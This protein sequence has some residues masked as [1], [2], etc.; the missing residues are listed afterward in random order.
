MAPR[1]IASQIAAVQYD[2][3]GNYWLKK[4]TGDFEKTVFPYS[5]QHRNTKN[6]G[7][8]TFMLR[9]P[10]DLFA[11]L[12]KVMN[13]SDPRL[14]MIL[15]AGLVLLLNKYTGSRDIL[16]GTTIYRQETTEGEFINTLLPL[17]SQVDE[18]MMFKDLL[19]QVRQSM[20]EAVKNQNYPMETLIYQL[21]LSFSREEFPLFGT[22][23]LLDNIHDKRYI[24]H[25]YLDMLFLFRREEAYIEAQV[26]YNKHLYTKEAVERISAHFTR[27]L[28]K[29]ISDVQVQMSTVSPL[30]LQERKLLLEEFNGSEVP[31]PQDKTLH[32]LF[33]EQV[34]KSPLATAL[35]YTGVQTNGTTTEMHLT[36]GVLNQRSNRLARLLRDKGVDRNVIVT[37]LLDRSLEMVTAMLAVLKAGGAYLP[38]LPD[39]PMGRIKSIL[40]NSN[41]NLLLTDG[42]CPLEEVTVDIP[43]NVTILHLPAAY[44]DKD[45]VDSGP[46]NNAEPRDLVYVI[47]TSGSTGNP[48]GVMVEHRSAVNV[49][50]WFNR[51]YAVK[52]RTYVLQMSDFIFDASVNQIFGTLLHG[53]TLFLILKEYLTDIQWLRRHIDTR[54]INLINFV[55]LLLKELL[56]GKP[57]LTSLHTVIS[58]ADSL[59]EEMKNEIIGNGYTLY[60]HYG[61]TEATIDVLAAACPNKEVVLG[62]PIS[63]VRCYVLDKYDQLIPPGGIGELCAAGAGL[64]RG[65]LNDPQLT[66]DKF[67]LNPFEQAQLMYRTGDLV[68]WLPDGNVRFLGRI[69]Q[70]VKIRGFRIEL[71]EIESSLLTHPCVKEALVI[72]MED[73][74]GNKLLC[75]YF[76]ANDSPGEDT[77]PAAVELVKYLSDRLPLYMIPTYIIR[78]DAVPV[79]P[80]GKV[81]RKALPPP[82]LNSSMEYIPPRDQIEKKLQEIWSEV[83]AVANE[84]ISI[85]ADFFQLGGHSLKA[86]I[87]IARIHKELEVKLPL[88]EIFKTP[89]IRELAVYIKNQKKDKY[90]SIEPTEKRDYY[91]LSA[92]QKRLYILQQ[93]ESDNISYNIPHI[94]PLEEYIDRE[95]LENTFKKI[96]S[97]HESLRTS[98]EIVD[99]NPIQRIHQEADLSLE[100]IEYDET[101]ALEGEDIIEKLTCTFDLSKAPLL[102]V[103]LLT[104]APSRYLL[105]LDI[106]HIVTD[107]TS[108][109]LLTKNF[110]A[111]YSEEEL[112]PIRIHYKDF[113]QWQNHQKQQ[114]NLARQENF[115]MRKFSGDTPPVLN[116]PT[117][118]PRPLIQSFEGKRVNFMLDERS[119]QTLRNIAVGAGATLFIS[120]L[121]IYTFLLSRLSSQEDIIVGI[122]VEGRRHA[123]LEQIVGMFVNTLAL[124]NFPI[125][126][127]TFAE[128][129]VEVKECTL[130]AI[131]NQEY[132][133]E[134]LVEKVSVQRDA[135][136]NPLFDV[137]LNALN[138]SQYEGD[139]PPEINTE[140]YHHQKGVSKFDMSWVVI[141]FAEK[142]LVGIEYS[143]RLFNPATIERFIRYFKQ[144]LE[145]LNGG[146]EIRL[147]EIE[148]IPG[149]EKQ[150]ILF[151]FNDTDTS[152]EYAGDQTIHRL[153]VEQA[154]RTPGHIAVIGQSLQCI[155]PGEESLTPYGVLNALSY[156][157]LDKKSHQLAYFLKEQG[158]QPDTAVGIMVERSIEMIVGIIGILKAGGAYLPI[159]PGYPPERINYMLFDSQAKILL[160]TKNISKPINLDKEMICLDSSLPQASLNLSEARH[161]DFPTSQLP[162]FPAFLPS[163]LAYIIYTS[164]STGKPK[165]VMVEHRN[166]VNVVCW[167]SRSYL[168]QQNT[169]HVLMMSDY[170]FD[171]SVN[172]VFGTLLHGGVLFIMHKELI[173]NRE[174]LR[175]YIDRHQIHV[176]NFVPT[177]LNEL[178][179]EGKRLESIRVVLSGGER[180]EDRVKHNI[181][182]KG[183]ALYN[184]Y[185]PTETTI[186]ALVEKCSKE[187]VTLGKPIANTRCYIVDKYN[188]LMPVG[189][190]GELYV[191]GGGVSRGYLNQPGLT[192]EKFCLWQP[193][194][195]SIAHGAWRIAYGAKHFAILG[196]P[197]RGAPEP[198]TLRKNFLL[199]GTRGLAPLLRRKKVPGKRIYLHMSYMSYIYRTG[200]LAKWL[201]DGN[202]E[203]LGR[204]DHQIK[205]RGFRIE[206]GE[207]ESQLSKHPGVKKALVLA[208]GDADDKYLCAYILS[209]S[210]EAFDKSSSISSE[211]RQYLLQSLP[212][213][214]I[215]SY[216]VYLEKI[217]MAPSGKIDRKAL[218]KPEPEVGQDHI[219]PRDTVEKRL[220]ELWS[221]VLGIEK[222]VIGINDDFF[223]LSGHSLKAIIMATKIH[224]EFNVRVS[225]AQ[226]FRTSTIR[227][228]S[229]TIMGTAENKFIAIA[230]SA[231][232]EYYNLS[233]AQMRLYI[234]HQL[235]ENKTS[236]NM[237]Y[238]HIVEGELE[239]KQLEKAAKKLIERHESLRTSF[240]L[241]EGEPVQ[242]IH[243]EVEFGLDFFDLQDVGDNEV[244]IKQLTVPFDLAQAS[245]MR[246]GIIKQSEKRHLLVWNLHHII[247]DGISMEILVKDFIA[248]Y[249]GNPL[250]ALRLQYKDYSQW[251]RTPKQEKVRRSHEQY[252]AEQFKGKIPQLNLP[253]DYPRPPQQGT[254]GNRLFFTLNKKQTSLIKEF[255][256]RY[257]VTLFMFLLAVLNVLFSKLSGQEDI[258]I[259]TSVSGRQHADLENIVGFFVN[260]LP[261]R[262]YP[263]GQKTFN[264]FLEEIKK[265]AVDTFENQDYPFESLVDKLDIP[266]NSSRNPLFDVLFAF[267]N[268]GLHSVKIPE[269]KTT[270][271]KILPY[272][273]NRRITKY[274]ITLLARESRDTLSVT[275]L[276]SIKLFKEETIK[277]YINYFQQV[278]SGVLENP[279]KELSRLEI[280]ENEEK[281]RLIKNIRAEQR[282][283][284]IQDEPIDIREN[285]KET[286]SISADFDF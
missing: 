286:I 252:W 11:K 203:F 174:T 238:I 191:G 25:I 201:V 240:E 115:W 56:C 251:Q 229:G 272:P 264:Q 123:D 24:S 180:L 45:K 69:D 108:Q 22:A 177:L 127:K 225:L 227:G 8:E 75:A 40:A 144:V 146:E 30:S 158:V 160:T 112:P 93:L 205:I 263:S 96:I 208:N 246:V 94:I 105:F 166:A 159:E 230:K 219:A 60:N 19:L 212:D 70:Q 165:G 61:P 141:D 257:E 17:R 171:P 270:N 189:I 140:K 10:Q 202:I 126:E 104:A 241:I 283:S 67:V 194:D 72:P 88:A 39:T 47:Y 258:V 21:G 122:P 101:T 149:E 113:S 157:E 66:H 226:I 1:K 161:P 154:A 195:E 120:F 281:Y 197:R 71:A 20:V 135:G 199:K 237:S 63:N 239:R 82:I 102:R 207:I 152:F 282:K 52:N 210:A 273:S 35:V 176:I 204:M 268:V 168:M 50:L 57:P 248:L 183:Y 136:R 167:F 58:G 53:G 185:G 224:K 18:H 222:N 95:R 76:V 249:L 276:Y 44:T 173:M 129:L 235:Q 265:R 55:P 36:Y 29:I 103:Y 81:D 42:S 150:Q 182:G 3:E 172:Q 89:S 188:H 253:T 175:Q 4:M 26:E 107:G 83:L 90:A 134:D 2:K 216:F 209:N 87:L 131:D 97:R 267:Q 250:P 271:L 153:F 7:I 245:L 117:D 277:K 73:E 59:E 85:D 116:L 46:A 178:L 198:T 34:E 132:Q 221:E 260:A 181:I 269:I 16:L 130:A 262:N 244:V 214:M 23:I 170:T 125:G 206:V 91:Q 261:M 169:T 133:F 200:D 43:G 5:S 155:A 247:V 110:M 232:K 256:R 54:Q 164:G 266:R 186:D 106:H 139:I 111:L 77:P 147:S 118:Y 179:A 215:P 33:E 49:V 137:M 98:F 220:A 41:S 99:Q 213:Y 234:L 62:K 259:G 78:I 278:I 190:P 128:F 143:S 109:Y 193:G 100:Y 192:A 12:T 65:Y 145:V 114:E 121:S 13:H 32:V 279:H 274:D 228:L 80:T 74:R 223:E 184:Q 156:R 163:N 280:L 37:L 242:R 162:S 38:L 254:E 84:S 86:T 68:Q 48:K 196:S 142:L 27:L 92:A 231:E 285:E 217:P 28:N 14:H 9:F 243:D 187:K 284:F 218:P 233:S 211:L 6:T 79:T 148:I 124:R 15:T 275:I 64:A 151:G 236:F 31:W 51:Q 119:T 138:Q 255:T